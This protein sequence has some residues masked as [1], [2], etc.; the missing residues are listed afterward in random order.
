MCAYYTQLL[1]LLL[2]R[3]RNFSENN[4]AAGTG[5]SI[6]AWKLLETSRKFLPLE[7]ENKIFM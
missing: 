5:K 4:M 6:I 7:R 3:L 2:L 1:S